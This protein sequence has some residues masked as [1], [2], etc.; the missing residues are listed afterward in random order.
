[1]DQNPSAFVFHFDATYKTNKC[2]Y[3]LFVCG[4]SDV[5]R[6]FFPVAF[7]VS[8]QQTAP[9]YAM[10]LTALQKVFEAVVGK[11]L[12]LQHF[13]GDADLAQY[14]AFGKHAQ[15]LMCYF[16]VLQNV[17]KRMG[18]CPTAS[19]AVHKYIYKMHFARSFG[20]LQSISA[21]A[22]MEWTRHPSLESF[23][24]YFHSQWMASDMWRWQAYHTPPGMAV[25]NNPIESFNR[26]IKDSV[27]LRVRLSLGALINCMRLHDCCRFDDQMLSVTH[28]DHVFRP[29]VVQSNL[30]EKAV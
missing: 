29:V 8:S 28:H 21:E 17:K 9:Q 10:A 24:P 14:S 7:F 5:S 2:G 4:I 27:T 20:D 6:T 26:I 22:V 23:I 1:M 15:F 18:T 25:T 3:P 30:F 13:M 11:D 16:H 19:A 12:T